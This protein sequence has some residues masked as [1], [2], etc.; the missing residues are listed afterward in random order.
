MLAAAAQPLLDALHISAPTV[1][2]AVRARRRGHSRHR[3]VRAGPVAGAGAAGSGRRGGTGARAAVLRPG[4][5]LL[6]LSVAADHGVAPGR[7]GAVLVVAG[8]LGAG[9]VAPV[10]DGPRRSVVR[11]LMAVL[12]VA[13]IAAAVALAVDGVFDV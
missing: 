7:I 3:P 9:A 2:I 12:A 13:A 10:G 6:A 4:L 5:A 11:W 8:T 1:R